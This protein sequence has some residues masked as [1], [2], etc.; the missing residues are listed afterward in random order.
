MPN[1]FLTKVVF[2]L[3]VWQSHIALYEFVKLAQNYLDT[4]KPNFNILNINILL[5][6]NVIYI[7]MYVYV[8][9]SMNNI[10]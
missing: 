6:I 1:Q 5:K 4:I 10:V 7:C 2:M 3:L 8:L 9:H